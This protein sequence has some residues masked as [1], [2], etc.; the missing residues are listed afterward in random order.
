MAQHLVEQQQ[1][2]LSSLYF[3]SHR[4]KAREKVAS[5]PLRFLVLIVFSFFDALRVQQNCLIYKTFN[6]NMF[7]KPIPPIPVPRQPLITPFNFETSPFDGDT[8]QA[9]Q[10]IPALSQLINRDGNLWILNPTE[11]PTPEIRQDLIYL[12]YQ[13]AE[14]TKAAHRIHMESMT[15]YHVNLTLFDRQVLTINDNST[16]DQYT[17]DFHIAQ[18]L[19]PTPP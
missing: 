1:T 8:R 5:D 14:A 12:E 13:Q 16:Y 4:K 10:L 9:H 7:S 15:R 17:K 2:P 19:R 3:A 6:K 11:H 18:L